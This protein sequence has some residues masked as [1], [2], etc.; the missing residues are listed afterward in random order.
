MKL[1]LGDFSSPEKTF[2]NSKTG[3]VFTANQID[4]VFGM[5][6]ANSKRLDDW[7]SQFITSVRGQWSSRR[8]LTE[9]QLQVL[10]RIYAE[11]TPC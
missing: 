6:E 2:R 10:E 5:I 9:P 7:E 1:G 4:R 3:S 11:K 8:N